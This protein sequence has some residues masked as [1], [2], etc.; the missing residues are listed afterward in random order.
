MN[1]TTNEE[2]DLLIVKSS[3]VGYIMELLF[4]IMIIIT[5]LWNTGT[6]LAFYNVRALRQKPS[7]FLSLSCADFIMGIVLAFNVHTEAF[8]YWIWWKVGCQFRSCI[9]NTSIIVSTLSTLWISLDRYILISRKYPKYVRLQSKWRVTL[10]IYATWV[11]STIA[12]FAEWIVR[13][14][15]QIPETVY[16]FNYNLECRS[17]PKHNF[18]CA[19]QGFSINVFLPLI[20]IEVLCV[21]FV[22]L[23][24]QKLRK[25]TQ[26]SNMELSHSKPRQLDKR[27]SNH[28][29]RSTQVNSTSLVNASGNN[30]RHIID[31]SENSGLTTFSKPQN[32]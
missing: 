25:I 31:S 9:E 19:T 16:Q 11:Y 15:V 27:R 6:I 12:A 7:N 26:T 29:G 23:L 18:I 28:L 20:G 1:T 30:S 4:C 3:A 14:I 5:F 8:G 21:V 22:V 13:D 24:R 2:N 10:M 32:R 17:P